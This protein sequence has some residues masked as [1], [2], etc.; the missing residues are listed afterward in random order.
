M[1]LKSNINQHLEKRVYILV[2]DVNFIKKKPP[3]KFEFLGLG[4]RPSLFFIYLFFFVSR[5]LASR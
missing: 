5:N 4:S 2:Y 1:A 3:E